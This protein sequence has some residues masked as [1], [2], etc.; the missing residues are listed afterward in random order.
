MSLHQNSFQHIYLTT[1]LINEYYYKAVWVVDELLYAGEEF[2]YKLPALTEPLA[3][4]AVRI[5]LYQLQ[6]TFI[7]LC[8]R[9]SAGT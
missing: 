1:Y 9:S 5:Y 3:E 6:G 8:F 4:E 2:V 7:T